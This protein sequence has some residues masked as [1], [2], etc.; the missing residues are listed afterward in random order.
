MPPTRMVVN[1][2][3]LSTF[4]LW[5]ESPQGLMDS[6]QVRDQPVPS[7]RAGAFVVP[8]AASL[9]PRQWTVNATLISPTVAQFQ[10]QWDKVKAVLANTWLE[11]VFEPWTDRVL[12]CRYQ[13]ASLGVGPLAMPGGRITLTF[14]APSPYLVAPQVDSY[15]LGAGEEVRPVLGT[16][17]S[18]FVVRFVGPATQPSLIYYDVNG[19]VRGQI[20]IAGSIVA[21]EWIEFDTATLTVV[22]VD[23]N[24]LR[25][26]GAPSVASTTT[27]FALDPDDG[28]ADEGPSIRL[29]Q[30]TAMVYVRRAWR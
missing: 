14:L 9:Q 30:G 3:D 24:S 8:R 10:A 28:T 13:G 29:D 15:G 22:K 4:D 17:P 26:N 11:V 20:S 12:L 18:S 27:L 21:R 6:P 5:V 25:R 19:R 2:V 23:V 1:G 7:R 16:A